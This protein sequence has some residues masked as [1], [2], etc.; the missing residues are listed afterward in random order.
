MSIAEME[1]GILQ[2]II[3]KCWF[4]LRGWKWSVPIL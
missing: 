4:F 2:G 3:A 1:A